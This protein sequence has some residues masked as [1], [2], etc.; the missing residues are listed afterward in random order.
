MDLVCFASWA[1]VLSHVNAG[2]SVWY[3]A[4]LNT[5]P[6]RVRIARVFKNGKLRI[7]PLSNQA[8]NFTADA[9]HLDRFRK[10]VS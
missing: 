4:P 5:R 6:L 2:H 8:D 1:D 7:D 3:Q 10:R 9:E